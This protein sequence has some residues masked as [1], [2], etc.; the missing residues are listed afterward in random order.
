[1]DEEEPVDELDS[2]HSLELDS[3]VNGS[4]NHS[5]NGAV[6]P[7]RMVI[8]ARIR[9]VLRGMRRTSAV[10]VSDSANV[11]LTVDSEPDSPDPSAHR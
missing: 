7:Q 8:S 4:G 10:D 9:D 11:A 3:A 1:M 5:A 6:A 2:A